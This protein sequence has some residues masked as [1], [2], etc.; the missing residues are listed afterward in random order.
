MGIITTARPPKA[1]RSSLTPKPTAA[2]LERCRYLGRGDNQCTGEVLD[3]AAEILLC[4]KHLARALQLIR[5][6]MQ[7]TGITRAPAAGS[8]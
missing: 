1:E 5:R 3:P 8:N 7:S 2:K 4:R 6:G